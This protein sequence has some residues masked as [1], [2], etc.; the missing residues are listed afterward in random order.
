M[1]MLGC[2][3]NYNSRTFSEKEG[4]GTVK[5]GAEELMEVCEWLT[6]EINGLAVS[7]V[8]NEYGV[9][10]PV[11][12]DAGHAMEELAESYPS[13]EGYYPQPKEL[14]VSELLS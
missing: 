11:E 4:L 13:L 5:Y 7:V 14:I 3:I 8:R 9:M 12:G 6:D 1:Y 2:G 10:V